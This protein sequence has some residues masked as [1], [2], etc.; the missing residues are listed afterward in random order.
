[1]GGGSAGFSLSAVSALDGATGLAPPGAEGV[2]TILNHLVGNGLGNLLRVRAEV[3]SALWVNGGV[4]AGAALADALPPDSVPSVRA[5]ARYDRV[6]AEIDQGGFAF[7]VDPI[8]AR[9]FERRKR[10]VPRQLNQVDIV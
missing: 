8:D 7:A 2:S 1:M 4:L 3:H 10:R 9:F 5:G 6:L